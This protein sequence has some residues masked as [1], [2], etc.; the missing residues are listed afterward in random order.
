M[1][2]LP[3]PVKAGATIVILTT[4]SL[5]MLLVAIAT[6]FRAP[7]LY[8]ESILSRIAELIL[9]VFGVELEIVHEA[10]IPEGQVV[11]IANHPST[12]DTFTLPALRLPNARFFYYGGWRKIPPFALIGH[13]AGN[14]WTVAQDYP[15]KRR[16]I[17]A[18][19][20]RT[21][22]RTGES[23]FLSP[24]GQRTTGGVIGP[25]NKGAFHLATHL[26]APIVPLFIEVPP[27]ID[28]GLGFDA[29]PGRVRIC[30]G[31]AVDTATWTLADLDK[32]REALRNRYVEWNQSRALARSAAS[33]RAPGAGD[34]R[35]AAA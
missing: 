30:V 35:R 17:F 34:A 22:E 3:F 8:R 21:L 1:R 18:D 19:A 23:V 11:F 26:K 25:F 15:E 5:V 29:K 12:I 2:N 10:P 9:D 28:P 14:F 7:R 16:E 24:E 6:G 31:A 33:S 27:E 4:G 13:L 20:A 32:N